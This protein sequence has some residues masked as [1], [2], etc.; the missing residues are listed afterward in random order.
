MKFIN[1]KAGACALVF[2]VFGLGGAAVHAQKCGSKDAIIIPTHNWSSQIVMSH[3]VGQLFEKIGCNVEY[4]STDSQAVYEAVRI[5]DAALELEVW[6]GSFATSFNAALDKGGLLDAGTHEA[7]TR[8]E[9]WYPTYVGDLCPGL[10][11]WKALAACAKMFSRPD[12]GGKG[13]YVDGPVEWLH[14]HARIP[15][16]GMD[17][18]QINVGSAAALWAELE[19]AAKKNKPI[20]MFNWSPNFTDALYGGSFIEF[21]AF[22]EKCKTDAGWGV[23]PDATNDCG[24]P[25]GGYLKKAA[26]HGMPAKWPAA[27]KALTRIS[28]TTNQIGTMAVYVDVEEMEHE[29]AATRWIKENEKVWSK[30]LYASQ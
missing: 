10:P 19:A 3:V 9:W 7:L 27:Y 17:F 6:E 4:T 2:A 30:W 12:S 5:G 18:T 14:D 26:W 1:I 11:D 22:H 29:E 21:P 20:V 13:V 15:A 8:E 23:N 24:S 25:A 28:F 16:L